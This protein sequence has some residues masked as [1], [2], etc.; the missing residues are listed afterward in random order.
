VICAAEKLLKRKFG[1]DNL[2]DPLIRR[3]AHIAPLERARRNQETSTPAYF[4]TEQTSRCAFA[5]G[6]DWNTNREVHRRLGAG[7]ST[8]RFWHG[9]GVGRKV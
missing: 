9:M 3:L 2:A 6:Q 4:A 7:R 8:I 5:P 1:V